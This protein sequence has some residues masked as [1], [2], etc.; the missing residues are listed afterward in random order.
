M[1]ELD[2]N[3]IRKLNIQNSLSSYNLFNKI[4]LNDK[5]NIYK[6]DILRVLISIYYYEKLL[7]YLKNDNIF[8][9]KYNYYLINTNWINE[10]KK[11]YNYQKLSQILNSYKLSN[12]QNFENTY[13]NL[14][15]NIDKIKIYLNENKF[16][17]DNNKLFEDL[18]NFKKINIL[19]YKNNNKI[20]YNNCYII[21]FKIMKIIKNYIFEGKEFNI[22]PKKIFS[23][24]NNIFLNVKDNIIYGYLNNE[25]IFN[26]K[27]ILS[28]NSIDILK[29]EKKFL[30]EKSF[31]DYLKFRNVEEKNSIK[32]NLKNENNEIIGELG[33]L[34][35]LKK[36]YEAKTI[37]L[38]K[39]NLQKVLI[40]IIDY[41]KEIFQLVG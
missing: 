4:K 1:E 29:N 3:D 27:Y 9:E 31:E 39:K 7:Y 40:L 41:I 32:K 33:E 11:Y 26:T 17:I 12:S 2:K 22:N 23:R 34:M 16:N 18:T 35:K 13:K 36:N 38:K 10:F 30:L 19:P 14:N 5:Q 25:L 21:D 6:T 28:Y 24:G 15:N 8:N 20:I 37:D